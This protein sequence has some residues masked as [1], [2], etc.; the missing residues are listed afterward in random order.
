LLFGVVPV[1]LQPNDTVVVGT[2]GVFDNMKGASLCNLLTESYKNYWSA[3]RLAN[4]I[5][6][7]SVQHASERGGKP[8]DVTAVVGYVQED[9][10]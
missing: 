3:S 1:Q 6:E 4:K 9:T 7:V 8:D 5:V 10:A 2:D